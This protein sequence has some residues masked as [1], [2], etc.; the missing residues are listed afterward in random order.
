M[1]SF[2]FEAQNSDGRSLSGT[3]NSP[4]AAE[5]QAT[6]ESL[7]YR[8]LDLKPASVPVRCSRLSI[9]ELQLFNEQL[10]QLASSGLPM[11]KGLKLLA[12]DMR[13]SPARAAMEGLASDLSTGKPLE[14]AIESRR[15]QFPPIYSHLIDAGIKTSNLPGVLHSF[16]RHLDMLQRIKSE[17]WRACAYPMVVLIAFALLMIFLGYWVMPNYYDLITKLTYQTFDRKNWSQSTHQTPIP[18]GAMMVYTVGRL[19]PFIL[20]VFLAAILVVFGVW[21]VLRG[22]QREGTWI[23]RFVLKFPLVGRA[24]HQSYITRWVDTLSIGIRAGLDLPKS[25]DLAGQVVNLPSLLS[26]SAVLANQMYEGK[27]LDTA[28]PLQ[29]LPRSIPSTIEL[30]S[31][32]GNLPEVLEKLTDQLQKQTENRIKLIPAT[33]LPILVILIGICSGAVV[34]GLWAPMTN[35]LKSLTF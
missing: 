31:R 1:N 29:R 25:I 7:Q 14:D 8:V 27:P 18:F 21:G 16:G 5:A 9:G 2:E 3:I 20:M 23:E 35:V 30:A 15:S 32:T 19:M 28:T 24:M 34:Y 13:S 6:I 33:V 22:S 12:S 10:Q 4:T 26:D 11:E 17:L